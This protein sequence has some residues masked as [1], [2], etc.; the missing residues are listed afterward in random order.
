MMKFRIEHHTSFD[1]TGL[2]T[3]EMIAANGFKL[4]GKSINNILHTSLSSQPEVNVAVTRSITTAARNEARRKQVTEIPSDSAEPES[5]N[6]DS[7]P[8]LQI[9][10]AAAHNDE[11]A[12]V[13]LTFNLKI[14]D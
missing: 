4:F 6:S 3:F 12:I 7:E 2:E 9:A 1:F 10:G 11:A 5:D 8:E 13:P 14:S